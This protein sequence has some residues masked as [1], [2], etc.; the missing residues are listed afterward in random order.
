MRISDWSSD[1]CSSDLV[2]VVVADAG[3][4]AV[5]AHLGSPDFVDGHRAG[6]V[7]MT[8]A[9]RSPGSTLKPLLYGLAFD[10]GFLDPR[11]I[12]T[13]APLR[14]SGYA[15][16]NFAPAHLGELSAA[17]ALR[18]SLNVPAV[19]V[20]DRYGSAR[21]VNRR[22][23]AGPAMELPASAPRPGPAIGQVSG[24]ERECKYV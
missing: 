17:D 1:V 16:A 7:D 9:V 22:T 11:S 15:P 21:F 13:D 8:R 24:R 20:L 23:A 3:S 12:V 6:Q 18:L 10:D 14:I 2:A 4:G 5:L 19:A